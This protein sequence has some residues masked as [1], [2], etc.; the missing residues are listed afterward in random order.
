MRQ[1]QRL[2]PF[3]AREGQSLS[4]RPEAEGDVSLLLTDAQSGRP[5]QGLR[6][7]CSP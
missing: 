6:L 5:I 2:A 1:E 7:R 4:F 3:E